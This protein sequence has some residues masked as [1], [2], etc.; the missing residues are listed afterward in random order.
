MIVLRFARDFSSSTCFIRS[1]MR[2]V[3]KRWRVAGL[4]ASIASLRRARNFQQ[5]GI[6]ERADAG[7]EMRFAAE[8]RHLTPNQ[9][10]PQ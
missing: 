2:R 7:P 6:V 9:S 5:H 3:K 4:R 1:A 10:P 8:Q